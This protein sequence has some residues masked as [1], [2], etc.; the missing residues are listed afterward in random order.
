M[1]TVMQRHFFPSLD[2]VAKAITDALLAKK[3]SLCLAMEKLE[4]SEDTGTAIMNG[5]KQMCSYICSTLSEY[6]FTP[7]IN[8]VCKDLCEGNHSE[9]IPRTLKNSYA[10][11]SPFVSEAMNNFFREKGEKFLFPA[12][13]EVLVEF[14]D[15]PEKDLI[16]SLVPDRDVLQEM[17]KRVYIRFMGSYVRDIVAGIDIG[18]M[19]SE[20]FRLMEPE[21]IERLVVSIVKKELN[22]VVI[23][24]GVLGMIIGTVN[25]FF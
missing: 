5:K 15:R 9:S 1:V 4:A 13:N 22:Y 14:G 20:K 12:I 7:V 21:A 19:I 24:G 17:I 18:G 6:N 2:T 16:T 3:T 23:L 10:S 11:F 8:S 25:I